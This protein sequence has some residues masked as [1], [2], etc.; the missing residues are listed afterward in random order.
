MTTPADPDQT[1]S[2]ATGRIVVG[3]DGSEASREAVR[4]AAVEARRR[5]RTLRIASAFGPDYIF[6][7]DEECRMYTEKVAEQ[8]VGEARR[9]GAGH[10]GGA[11]GTSRTYPRRPSEPRA[12]RRI[13]W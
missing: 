9:A 11:P 13:S 3:F 12:G 4:W 2:T 5:G 7:S 8:A 1:V 10:H 6:M